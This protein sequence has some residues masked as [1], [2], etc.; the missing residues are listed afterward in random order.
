MDDVSHPNEEA[1]ELVTDMQAALLE[2]LFIDA[3]QEP[4]SEQ[5]PKDWSYAIE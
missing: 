3:H 5:P 4:Q 2:R 1:L